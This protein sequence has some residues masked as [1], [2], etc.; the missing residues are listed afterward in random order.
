MQDEKTKLAIEMDELKKQH[1][2]ELEDERRKWAFEC[3]KLK[4]ELME[5]KMKQST[6]SNEEIE[7][8]KAKHQKELKSLLD[9]LEE[10]RKNEA[11]NSQQNQGQTK[12]LAE[13]DIEIA[14]LTQQLNLLKQQLKDQYLE[15]DE[16]EQKISQNDID[17]EKLRAQLAN[18]M[19][20]LEHH[21]Q[22]EAS[23]QS[24]LAII[25]EEHNKLKEDYQNLLI[26]NQND[27]D[28]I[29]KLL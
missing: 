6:H 11:F 15:I 14:D 22:N 9:E 26:K 20:Q 2:K 8:M 25:T 12:I 19:Q 27:N 16:K 1:H 5:L 29:A 24:H 10:K 3:D 13:K 23:L 4:L 18:M 7:E 21:K 17:L 28:N